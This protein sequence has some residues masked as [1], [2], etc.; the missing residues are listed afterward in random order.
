M[1]RNLWNKAHTE[2]MRLRFLKCGIA[3]NDREAE[4]G[5][6][7]L[8]IHPGPS[9]F[10][11]RA[12]VF[13]PGITRYTLNIGLISDDPHR[14]I[15]AF[16]ITSEW[17]D[18]RVLEP[19]ERIPQHYVDWDPAENVLNNSLGQAVG[20]GRCREG[21]LLAEGLKVP[22]TNGRPGSALIMVWVYDQFDHGYSQTLAVDVSGIDDLMR[23]SKKP[24]K[25]RESVF[26]PI[27][28]PE[29]ELALI[30]YSDYRHNRGESG[31][32]PARKSASPKSDGTA[33]R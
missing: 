9:L 22:A 8:I 23:D 29:L 21:L 15:S 33:E 30:D 2:E 16:R 27:D 1:K 10:D 12:T 13:S 5:E 14:V 6:G 19:F 28:G 31:L 4:A 18:I 32:N 25:A 11:C 24:R 7:G 26:T 20:P 3:V 17:E